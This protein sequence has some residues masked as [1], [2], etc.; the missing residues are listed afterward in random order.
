MITLDKDYEDEPLVQ[1]L[2]LRYNV[3]KAPAI[4]INGFKREGMVYD[5]ELSNIIKEKIKVNNAAIPKEE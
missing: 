4:I 2:A 1:L 5:Q 3:T